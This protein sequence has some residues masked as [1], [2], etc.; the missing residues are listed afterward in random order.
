MSELSNK[1]LATLL[2]V[3]IAVSV[4][5]TFL[6]INKPMTITGYS[7]NGTGVVNLTI[8]GLIALNVTGS[9]ELGN[10]SV[11]QDALYA[12]VDTCGPDTDAE[13]DC[14]TTDDNL[15]MYNQGNIDLN[16]TVVSDKTL[17]QFIGGNLSYANQTINATDKEAG[18]CNGT[19]ANYD[20]TLDDSPAINFCD[21][22]TNEETRDELYGCIKLFIPNDAPPGVRTETLLFTASPSLI[23]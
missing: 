20:V 13:G 2:V 17:A 7:T 1:T 8:T 11:R 10:C 12:I 19:G 9:I 6:V 5:G 22:F 3:A 15:T 4:L 23:Q 16:V 21:S 14:N 18:S